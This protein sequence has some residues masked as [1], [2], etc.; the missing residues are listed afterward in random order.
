MKLSVI[1]VSYNTSALLL[2]CLNSLLASL[3]EFL[4]ENE[5]EVIVVDNGSDDD[6]I[7][8]VKK[9]YPSFRL[10]CNKDNSGFSV[11]NNQGIKEA[12][13]DIVLLLNSDTEVK[14][15]SLQ[16]MYKIIHEDNKIAVVGGMLRGKN[17]KIQPSVGFFPTL[18]KVFLWM[19]FIDDLP[20]ISFLVKPYHVDNKSF[21]NSVRQVDWVSG[22]CMMLNRQA[23]NKV[24]ML[25]EKIF[26]YGEE[27][28]WCYRLKKSGYNIVYTNEA[29]ILHLKGASGSGESAGILEE[30]KALRY[31][32]RKHYSGWQYPILVALLRFGALLRL[33]L[34]GII[35]RYRKRVILYAKAVS[36]VGQ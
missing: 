12:K 36:M 19:T 24:G 20:I 23:I 10:I 2:N 11:A 4:S 30:F 35:G 15:D 33:I 22:A 13:G 14:K 9:H 29:E 34:F 17:G 1:I 5:Y 3:T 31:F 7:D 21:Y 6:S 26:M 28:E 18:S 25:D 27:M 8:V 32:Y 16:K